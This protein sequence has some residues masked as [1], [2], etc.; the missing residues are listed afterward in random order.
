VLPRNVDDE[1]R[2]A[3]WFM[4]EGGPTVLYEALLREA[5]GR[6]EPWAEDLVQDVFIGLLQL[7]RRHGD[8]LFPLPAEGRPLR[9]QPDFAPL[10][11]FCRTMLW[12]TWVRRWKKQALDE[13]LDERMHPSVDERASTEPEDPE[14]HEVDAIIDHVMSPLQP[15][16]GL[17]DY[18][19]RTETARRA[20]LGLVQTEIAS[21]SVCIDP[22]DQPAAIA[23]C[24]ALICAGRDDI[25]AE[26][27]HGVRA[28]VPDEVAELWSRDRQ[29]DGDPNRARRFRAKFVPAAWRA[30]EELQLVDSL[31][32]RGSAGATHETSDLDYLAKYHKAT[33]AR[34][35]GD[36]A[37][38]TPRGLINGHHAVTVIVR[39]RVIIWADLMARWLDPSEAVLVR[40]PFHL[41]LPDSDAYPY[42]EAAEA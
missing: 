36:L 13:S 31:A 25:I 37:A 18:I 9:A 3:T 28:T 29:R 20:A 40:P 23:Y 7:M 21:G 11:E 30:V 33:L 35:G 39:A 26:Q 5:S 34:A 12:R 19:A 27:L 8:A 32:R 24:Q 1:A 38:P 15:Y 2:F 42:A 41:W 14:W 16:V 4:Q 6:L 22:P 10:L 17:A